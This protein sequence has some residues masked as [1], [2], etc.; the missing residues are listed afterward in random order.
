MAKRKLY[1]LNNRTS[2]VFDFVVMV[3]KKFKQKSVSTKSDIEFLGNFDGSIFLSLLTFTGSLLIE[4]KQFFRKIFKSLFYSFVSRKLSSWPLIFLEHVFGYF[5]S[6]MLFRSRMPDGQVQVREEGN[7]R[8]QKSVS[9]LAKWYSKQVPKR[10][11]QVIID[12][13][14][15]HAI[16]KNQSIYT[17]G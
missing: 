10:E 13:Q 6:K 4:K 11:D 9:S 17:W 3:R 7:D 16:T 5:I 1:F 15:F 2:F 8:F 14:L 12:Q